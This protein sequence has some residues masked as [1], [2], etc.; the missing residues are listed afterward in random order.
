MNDVTE[1]PY[2]KN[3]KDNEQLKNFYILTEYEKKYDGFFRN[4][5]LSVKHLC[6]H[7]GILLVSS[8]V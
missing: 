8:A 7:P 3:N 1:V 5:D 4:L 2:K 6:P